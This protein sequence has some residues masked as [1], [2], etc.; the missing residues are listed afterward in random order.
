MR[1]PGRNLPAH[2][3]P[4]VAPECTGVP[5][6]PLPRTCSREW[7]SS[8]CPGKPRLALA[9][10]PRVVAEEAGLERSR[11]LQGRGWRLGHSCVDGCL[12]RC[13]GHPPRASPCPLVAGRGASLREQG[14][15]VLGGARTGQCR[16]CS[17][18]RFPALSSSFGREQGG[19]VD[20]CPAPGA[21]LTQ[22]PTASSWPEPSGELLLPDSCH[23]WVWEC[24][25]GLS[26]GLLPVGGGSGLAASGGSP[27]L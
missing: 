8:L 26:R 2:S 20:L 24:W 19:T 22:G 12:W 10:L 9:R 7:S 18:G 4:Q 16:S 23:G 1:A 21:R 25:L 11:G 13:S 6:R 17:R 3:W 14:T 5:L 27:P 15:R